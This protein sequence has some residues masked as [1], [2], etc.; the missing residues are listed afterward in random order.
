MR[1]SRRALVRE[2]AQEPGLDG[3]VLDHTDGGAALED[4]NMKK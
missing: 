3:E 2:E 1:G 4:M